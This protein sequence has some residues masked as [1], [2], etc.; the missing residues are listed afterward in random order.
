MLDKITSLVNALRKIP[1]GFLLALTI[2]LGLILF[3][4][5]TVAGKLAIRE[6]RGDYRKFLG[7][8]FLLGTA[9][10]LTRIVLGCGRKIE[11]RRRMQCRRKQLHDLTP[12]EMGYLTDF[13]LSGRNTIYVDVDDGIAGGLLGKSII[14]R[15][16]NMFNVLDGIPYNLQPWA[17]KYLEQHPEL[18]DGAVGKP[19]TPEQKLRS[20]W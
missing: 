11:K 15:S 13:V 14:Y 9:F 1:I 3:L 5:D 4:P 10:L 18:L 20:R 16:S 7:P 19:L 2:V 8:A 12:E 17:R 6:F